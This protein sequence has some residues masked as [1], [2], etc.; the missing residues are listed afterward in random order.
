MLTRASSQ[1]SPCRGEVEKRKRKPPCAGQLVDYLSDISQSS[2]KMAISRH[3]VTLITEQLSGSYYNISLHYT[4]I[5]FNT[6]L[7]DL[8]T[9]IWHLF[10]GN[11][12]FRQRLSLQ[13]KFQDIVTI[14]TV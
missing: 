10:I 14:H 13:T 1:T 11:L 5:D 6:S 3:P 7:N 9:I 8:G 2:R 12:G 4:K